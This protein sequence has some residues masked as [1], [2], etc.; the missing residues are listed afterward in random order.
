MACSGCVQTCQ[1]LVQG[2]T[3]TVVTGTGSVSNPYVV[4]AP[5]AVLTSDS[6]LSDARTPTAHAA[7]HLAGGAD[8]ITWASVHGSG[9]L[10]ARPAAGST[11]AGYLYFAEDSGVLYRSNG[12]TWSAISASAD[13]ERL[14]NGGILTMRRSA[15]DSGGYS[16]LTNGVAYFTYFTAPLGISINTL[17]NLFHF[18]ASATN[19]SL[20]KFGLYSVDTTTDT[21]TRLAVT[22]DVSAAVNA[23]APN[24]AGGS[25]NASLTTTA[26]LVAGSRYAF[27][28]LET[29]STVPVELIGHDVGLTV[30][31]DLGPRMTAAVTGQTD[32]VASY[33]VGSLTAQRYQFLAGLLT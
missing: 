7:S 11:N 26:S 4:S 29:G 16:P 19:P 21:L 14:M 1:C 8:A 30:V 22:G 9:L 5:S 20:L 27:A 15:V 28:A 33:A 6:R 3:N 31:S 2:G 17:R 10:S 12:T 23:L 24:A 32:L 25:Y 13:P 18:P